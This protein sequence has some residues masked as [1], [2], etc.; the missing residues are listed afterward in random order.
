MDYSIVNFQYVKEIPDFRIDAECY[1][2][3]YLKAEKLISKSDNKNIDELSKSVINFGAYSLCNYIEFLDTGVPFIVTQD[4]NDNL[5]DDK[6]F[7]YVSDEVHQIL[8]K[9]HCKKYQILL[10]MAGAYLGQAA[11]YDFEFTSS[12][13]QAIAKITIKDDVVDP[14]FLST[15]INSKYGQ[16]QIERFKTGTGQPNLNLGLIKALRIPMFDMSFQKSIRDTILLAKSEI[17]DSLDFYDKAEDLLL[18]EVA[19]KDFEIPAGLTWEVGYSE[20]REVERM[21]PDYFQPKY[22]ALLKKIKKHNLARLGEIVF[23]KK[24][25]EPGSGAYQDE[26]KL[27][28]RVSSISKNGVKKKDQKYLSEELYEKLKKDYQPQVGE[29][30]LTKDATPGIAYVLKQ[31]VEGILSGGILRLK[32]KKEIEPEYLALC[33]NSLV[34]RLQ[35][36]RDAGGSVIQH[37]RP[38]EIKKVLIP[39]L[40]KPTQQKIADLVKKSHEARKKSKELLEE[41][42]RKVEEMIEKGG[43]K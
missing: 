10:T 42:K 22:E 3:A 24:G 33:L 35:A 37:W 21:D 16:F 28:I 4:I 26:G 25:V 12:S 14:Y 32:L 31:P 1:K 11:V 30:L 20:A 36:E 43:K 17:R 2:P 8:R 7:H 5:I 15:F 23:M 38:S 9:S 29:A 41:A 6:N 19:L 27:F 18:E 34:G 13:N 39:V 40:P